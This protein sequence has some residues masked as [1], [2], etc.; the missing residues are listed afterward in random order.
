MK[1]KLKGGDRKFFDSGDYALSKAGK[2]TDAAGGNIDADIGAKRHADLGD[3]PHHSNSGSFSEGSSTG[4]ISGSLGGNG[5]AIDAFIPNSPGSH[6][7]DSHFDNTNSKLS[8]SPNGSMW[9]SNNNNNPA[10]NSNSIQTTITNSPNTTGA[11][12]PSHIPVPRSSV[13]A[14]NSNGSSPLSSSPPVS[15]LRP[16]RSPHAA[17]I[18]LMPGDPSLSSTSQPAPITA[19]VKE[20]SGLL[21]ETSKEDLMDED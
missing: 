20:S 10:S 19:A 15:S 12:A 6:H 5:F 1:K 4:S 2:D 18:S 13:L 9:N 16:P 17:P 7:H 3:I 8:S 11:S 21:N 14:S